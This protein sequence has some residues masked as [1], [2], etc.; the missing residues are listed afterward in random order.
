M[1]AR[2]VCWMCWAEVRLWEPREKCGLAHR[3]R[4]LHGELDAASGG[5]SQGLL[6]SVVE[7]VALQTAAPGQ[8]ADSVATGMRATQPLA[9]GTC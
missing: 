9:R 8:R 7:A 2:C 1:W 3:S 4:L 6:G 5:R